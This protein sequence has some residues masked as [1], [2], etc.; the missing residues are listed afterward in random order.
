MRKLYK[1][2]VRGPEKP[3]SVGL[4]ALLS[5]SVSLKEKMEGLV[6]LKTQTKTSLCSTKPVQCVNRE[7]VR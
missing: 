2:T 6:G 4:W 5:Q 1:A 7:R 3:V